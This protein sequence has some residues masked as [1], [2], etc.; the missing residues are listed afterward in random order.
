MLELVFIRSSASIFDMS[1]A[2][3]L[4][5]EGSFRAEVASRLR[6]GIVV[7]NLKKQDIADR[8]GMN[9]AS[10]SKRVNARLP[11]DVDEADVICAAIGLRR[12]WLLTGNGSML[13]PEWCARR[14]SN[15]QPSDP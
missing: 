9:Q 6:Q 8:I 12:D 15:S 11:I 1:T 13:D 3:R 4:R 2:I 5:P 7:R 10:F 14:D